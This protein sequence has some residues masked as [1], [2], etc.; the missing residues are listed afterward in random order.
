MSATSGT[1]TPRRSSAA[2]ISPRA[3]ASVIEG[4]VTRTISQPAAASCS[5]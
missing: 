5:A 2:R 1:R 4:A 3:S